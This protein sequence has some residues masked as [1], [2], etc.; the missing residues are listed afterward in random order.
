MG[1]FLSLI[2]QK[3]L[4]V[5]FRYFPKKIRDLIQELTFRRDILSAYGLISKVE[6]LRECLVR[7]FFKRKIILFYPDKPVP[8]HILYKMLFFLGYRS[9]TDPRSKWDL[10]I[11]WANSYDGNPFLPKRASVLEGVGK[12]SGHLPFLNLEA[13]SISKDHIGQIFN[14]VFGYP[15]AVDP[16]IF[17]GECVAKSNWNALHQGRIIECPIQCREPDVNYQRIIDNEVAGGLVEDFRVPIIGS[18]IPFVYRKYRSIENRFIDRKHTASGANLDEVENVFLKDETSM[19]KEF[20]KRLGLDYCEMD[21]LRDKK[22]GEIYVVDVNNTPSGP[23][24]SLST[25]E[26]KIS[27]LRLARTFEKEFLNSI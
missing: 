8:L 1:H 26:E 9:T 15:V 2:G 11:K 22:T 24:L 18:Q 5:L 21:V 20:S 14:E 25:M 13:E 23:P 27:I 4:R 12:D 6:V 10:A 17:T 7:C 19:L 3:L 16:T